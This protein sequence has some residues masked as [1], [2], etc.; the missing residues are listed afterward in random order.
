MADE[1]APQELADAEAAVATAEA[2]IKAAEEQE[3]PETSYA[4]V[5]P[6]CG[7][8]FGTCAHSTGVPPARRLV[9]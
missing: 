1:T 2:D 6:F 9:S 5:C 7:L 8:P 4:E 3:A